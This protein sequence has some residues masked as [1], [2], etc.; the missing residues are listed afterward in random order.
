[1]AT[2]HPQGNTLRSPRTTPP[3]LTHTHTNTHTHAHAHT[4]THRAP[5]RRLP[6]QVEALLKQWAG[7]DD[8]KAHDKSNVHVTRLLRIRGKQLDERQLR[9]A[10]MACLRKSP[11]GSAAPEV[12]CRLSCLLTLDCCCH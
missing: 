7:Q 2:L 3:P 4:H 6:P 11:G 5:L 9:A 10:L 8:D 1:M 12:G